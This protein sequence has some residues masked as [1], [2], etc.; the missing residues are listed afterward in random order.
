MEQCRLWVRLRASG[1]VWSSGRAWA[2]EGDGKCGRGLVAGNVGAWEEEL[3]AGAS[4]GREDDPGNESI[5]C[6]GGSVCFDG[7]G[8]KRNKF[9]NP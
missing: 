8:N 3:I 4:V 6:G 2:R 9:R 7:G 1:I 5:K